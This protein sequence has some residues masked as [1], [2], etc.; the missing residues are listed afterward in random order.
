MRSNSRLLLLTAALAALSL[1]AC[2]DAGPVTP[3]GGGS[4][5]GGSSDAGAGGGA[6]GGNVTPDGGLPVKTACSV[7]NANRCQYLSRCGLIG[8]SDTAIRDCISWLT[9]TWCGPSLWPS[10]VEGSPSTLRYD[11]LLANQCAMAFTSRACSDFATLPDVCTKFLSPNAFPGQACYDGYP[12]CTEGVCRGASCPRT[13]Q[14]RAAANEVCRE[15]TDCRSS[16]YCKLTSA[17]TGTGQCAAFG[18]FN[19]LC[20]SDEPC[21][22][23]LAC[24]NNKCVVPPPPGQPCAGLICDE[25]GFCDTTFDGGTCIERKDAGS[26]TD[27]VECLSSQLCEGLSGTCQPQKALGGAPCSARQSCPTGQSCVGATATALG[28]CRAPL[29]DDAGCVGS[30]DCAPHRACVARDAGTVCTLRQSA[31][32]PCLQDRDCQLNHRCQMARC[33]RLPTTGESCTGPRAC[34]FGPCLAGPDGGYFCVNPQGPGA[35]CTLDADCASNKC[36]AGQC[37]PSCAP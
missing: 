29:P 21:T 8:A 37:L 26:C 2:P 32:A 1:F 16:L 9:A 23:G 36:I 5:G 27:D 3:T 4:A 34:V 12:E 35:T 25:T 14:A 11:A 28:E 15:N 17:T 24:V 7:L 6:G 33:V 19:S 22:A 31:N 18:A 20:S 13:C 30:N 10:R